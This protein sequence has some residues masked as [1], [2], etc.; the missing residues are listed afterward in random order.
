MHLQIRGTFRFQGI[1]TIKAI[2]III[3]FVLNRGLFKKVKGGDAFKIHLLNLN[4]RYTSPLL[5]K[6]G[7]PW[8]GGVG[9]SL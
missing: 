8:G 9:Y 1:P 4:K 7:W 6:S 3:S 2:E 5:V